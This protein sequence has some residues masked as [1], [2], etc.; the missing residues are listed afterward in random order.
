MISPRRKVA[1]VV[2]TDDGLGTQQPDACRGADAAS[3]EV[4]LDRPLPQ[5]RHRSSTSKP[6]PTYTV[7]VAVDDP[8][9]GAQS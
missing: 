1:D 8:T 2:I 5:G 9:L 7:T 3:F 6:S 4:D